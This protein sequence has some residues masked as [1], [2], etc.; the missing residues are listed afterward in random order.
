M[1]VA[2][3]IDSSSVGG[4]YY[5]MLNFVNLVKEIKLEKHSIVFITRNK[6]IFKLLNKSGIK[7]Y[8]LNQ[9]C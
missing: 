1:R 5:H 8:F 6:K 2:F 3:F 9:A 7:N 4:G